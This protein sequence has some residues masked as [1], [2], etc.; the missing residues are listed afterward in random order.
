MSLDEFQSTP[1]QGGRHGGGFCKWDALK[2]SIHAPAGG[3]LVVMGGSANLTTFQSTPPQGGRLISSDGS[4]SGIWVSIH[5]PA[6]GATREGD[7]HATL[8][9]S[10]NPRPRRGGDLNAASIVYH[11]YVFQSTPPQGGRLLLCL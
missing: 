11:I 6:G 1:P 2:V 5:A 3:R 10:F 4:V 7:T 9:D 8:Y